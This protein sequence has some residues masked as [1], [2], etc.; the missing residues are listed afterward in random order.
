MNPYTYPLMTNALIIKLCL[1]TVFFQVPCMKSPIGA[2]R[3]KLDVCKKTKVTGIAPM[4]VMPNSRPI[5]KR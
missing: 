3:A 5:L 1:P 2:L 4:D